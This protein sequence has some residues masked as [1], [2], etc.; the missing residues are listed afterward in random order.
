MAL[1]LLAVRRQ[2]SVLDVWLMVVIWA[3]LLEIAFFVLLTAIRFS[4]SFYASRVFALVTAGIVLLLLLSETTRLYA[5]LARSLMLE[6]RER[7]ERLMTIDAMSASIV[8][9]IRQ[10]LGAM[11][12]SSDAALL[13]FDKAPPDLVQSARRSRPD[14]Q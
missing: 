11:M 5:R 2:K 12:A 1:T 14:F 10:P 6:R 4:L 9:E 7:E 13:W 3:W 8:H